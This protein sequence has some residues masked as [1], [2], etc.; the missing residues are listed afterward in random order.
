[1]PFSNV[2]ITTDTGLAF[3]P[4]DFIQIAHDANNIIFA[5]VVSYNPS[6]GALVATP[7]N[8][9]GSGTFTSWTVSLA[10]YFGSSGTSGTSGVAG[11]NGSSGTS[12]AKGSAGTSGTSGVIGSSGTSGISATKGS[13]GSSGTSGTRGSSGTA[14][15]SASSGT[16]GVGTSG[17][18]GTSGGSGSSGTSGGSGSSG[19]S[20]ARGSSG[21]S[22]TSGTSGASTS[23][24]TS[25]LSASSGT[26]GTSG[27]SGTAGI[28]G[29]SGVSGAIGSSGTSGVL[30]SSGSSG[31]S[32][33]SSGTSGTSGLSRDSGSSGTSG[34]DGSAGTAGQSGTSG[35]GAAG[36]IILGGGTLSSYRCGVSNLADGVYSAA[37]SGS[38]N[39][40]C[41]TNND[42][43]VIGGGLCNKININSN[44]SVIGGG[45]CNTIATNSGSNYSF[46][47]GGL[48]NYLKCSTVNSGIGGGMFNTLCGFYSFIGGGHC[49]QI[50]S[51]STGSITIGGGIGINTCGGTFDFTTL[52]FT[53]APTTIASG[54]LT[55]I[56][57]GFQ[58]LINVSSQWASIG[59][60]YCN[61][62]CCG[63]IS[64]IGGGNINK[65]LGVGTACV[66]TIGGGCCN[67]ISSSKVCNSKLNTIVGG[68]L[69]TISS[70]YGFIGGGASN[71]IVGCDSTTISTN[72]YSTIIGGK[73]NLI[74][75]S[76]AYTASSAYISQ[77]HFIGGG[78]KNEIN[79][80]MCGA[81]TIYNSIVGGKCNCIWSGYS[82]KSVQYS[83]IWGAYN[84]IYAGTGCGCN[85]HIWGYGITSTSCTTN[86]YL[87]VNKITA[88]GG[89]ISDCRVKES[90]KEDIYGLDEVAKL[91]PVSFCFAK[92]I[93][94]KKYGFIAQEVQEIMP[95]IIYCND[96][97]RVYEGKEIV[98]ISGKG[99]ALLQIDAGAIHVS[100]V[101]A[102]KQ[103]N[104]CF[105]FIRNEINI[106]DAI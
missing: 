56:V 106:L 21:T 52:L 92:N 75:T 94:E 48:N 72:A 8:Y 39:V 23:S 93:K 51:S 18:S 74:C 25:G 49:N 90:I 68:G 77:G 76:S 37:L 30:G 40:V 83:S 63:F 70:C 60:G 42:S 67:L 6:N 19:T 7:Y 28:T 62:I 61:E 50:D 99:D 54:Y 79:T 27:S 87:Y 14:G 46:I 2:S 4:F 84:I 57:G 29:T 81:S 26:A 78:Y 88:L 41:A 45:C 38:K 95:S 47:G 96:I 31:T 15:V 80:T 3:V 17:S 53:A 58:N 11:A 35:T 85:T 89:G 82:S 1:M 22:G 100:Y 44:N 103:L 43:S 98:N 55:T 71:C 64:F 104:S 102:I 73:Q 97:H 65:I 13:S 69:N 10:G 59:G 20:G 91:R 33:G 101:N 5:Q 12:G 16:A 32:G 24:G 105:D 34:V 9:L 36:I 66:N 86:D